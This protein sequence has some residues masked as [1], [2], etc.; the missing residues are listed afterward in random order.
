MLIELDVQGYEDRGIFG[1]REMFRRARACILELNLDSLY[2]GQAAFEGI[3]PLL[4]HFGHQ[5]AGNLDQVCAED[6]HVIYADALFINS[7]LKRR[8]C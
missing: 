2:E 8:Q 3:I 1:G 5:Y 6:G 4:S 7:D